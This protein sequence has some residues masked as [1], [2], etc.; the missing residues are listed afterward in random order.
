MWL[1]GVSEGE[2]VTG[3]IV[4]SLGGRCKPWALTLS[5]A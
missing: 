4:Q 5:E 3:L 2:E 1:V